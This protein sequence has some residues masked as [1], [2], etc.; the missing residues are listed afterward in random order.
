VVDREIYSLRGSIRP[1]NSGGPLLDSAGH[2]VGVIFARSTIDPDTGYAL[3]LDELRPVLGSVGSAAI[4]S[5]AC[6]VG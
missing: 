4:S 3:T 1:G 2:V 5:G 6:S